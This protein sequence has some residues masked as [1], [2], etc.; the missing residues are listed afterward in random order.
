ML[1]L[2][3]LLGFWLDS[4]SKCQ[5]IR[6]PFHH[7]SSPVLHVGSL[8][9]RRH[10]LLLSHVN[11][12]IFTSSTYVLWPAKSITSEVDSFFPHFYSFQ[13]WRQSLA[14]R[15]APHDVIFR[16]PQS[17]HELRH[18]HWA[19]ILAHRLLPYRVDLHM[20]IKDQGH[21]LQHTY[22][23]AVTSCKSYLTKVS[24]LMNHP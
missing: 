3:I 4:N 6:S 11:P 12:P 14:V 10:W 24:Y 2:P 20:W 18:I 9:S 16:Y 5:S 19:S 21:L 8:S 13:N 17:S 15:S 22:A 23:I 1:L 7:F